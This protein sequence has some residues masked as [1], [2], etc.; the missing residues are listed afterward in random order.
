MTT[1][2]SEPNLNKPILFFDDDKLNIENMKQCKNAI[3]I[4]VKDRD[5][6][7]HQYLLAGNMYA[8]I[9]SKYNIQ[10]PH[11][12][13]RAITQSYIDLIDKWILQTKSLKKRKILFDWDKTLSQCSGLYIPNDIDLAEERL[14]K[15]DERLSLEKNLSRS[16]ELEE[17]QQINKSIINVTYLNDMLIYL[18]G[19]TE[20][21]NMIRN[22]IQK[23]L[24]LN[25]E[26][27]IVTNNPNSQRENAYNRQVFVKMLAEIDTR[28]TDKNLISSSDTNND[29][30][31]AIQNMCVIEGGHHKKDK[32]NNRNKSKKQYNKYIK[33]GGKKTIVNIVET[34]QGSP[35]CP[36]NNPTMDELAWDN[37]YNFGK[38]TASGWGC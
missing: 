24:D 35:N 13:S 4:L 31:A 21:M 3:G 16:R 10:D 37:R 22:I 36:A 19:G 30:Y 28:L 5:I 2:I 7:L 32:N 20:R 11:K 17:E 18:L 38:G 33:R 25:I 15:I 12:A 9:L 27:Y 34:T 14:K 26:V 1:T 23:L 8:K 29:K 6:Y